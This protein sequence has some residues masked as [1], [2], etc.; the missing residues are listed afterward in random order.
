VL[1]INSLTKPE[2]QQWRGLGS[3]LGT[4]DTGDC[5]QRGFFFGVVAVGDGILAEF[6]TPL[7]L[8]PGVYAA[9]V[10]SRFPCD[11]SGCGRA[12]GYQFGADPQT[13][14]R[15]CVLHGPLYWPI[16][17]RAV[18]VALLVG[19]LLFVI[20]QSDVVLRGDITTLVVAKIMLTYLVPVSV[21]T[22]SA[23]AANRTRGR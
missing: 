12:A 2:K 6:L 3:T 1:P 14:E 21:S 20:N 7:A 8:V 4:R 17:R 11:V 15:R 5:A 9:A 19:T 23:L 18:R 16:V 13:C 22:F 10:R